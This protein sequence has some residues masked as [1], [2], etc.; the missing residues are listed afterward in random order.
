MLTVILLLAALVCFLL[1]A[2]GVP[3]SRVSIGWIGLACWVL[4]PL[5]A[6]I[7]AHG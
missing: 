7:G 1:A 6:A 5:L 3:T 2:F 4:V